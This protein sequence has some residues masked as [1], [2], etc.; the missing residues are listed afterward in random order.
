MT[1]GSTASSRPRFAFSP[2]C[3]IEL[4][5]RS[6]WSTWYASIYLV[7]WKK[8]NFTVVRY[9]VD[10]QQLLCMA[11]HETFWKPSVA[12]QHTA[13][14]TLPDRNKPPI[15][16]CLIKA[17]FHPASYTC[18]ADCS[19]SGVQAKLKFV[20]CACKSRNLWILRM[21]NTISRLR[22]FSDCAEQ[23]HVQQGRISLCVVMSGNFR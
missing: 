7:A 14:L 22:K 11:R 3:P 16:A 9:S 8:Y 4:S 2:F 12:Y 20:D 10:P 15:E 1:E 21:R 13:L 19:L 6:A 23:I 18:T 17:V 5:T